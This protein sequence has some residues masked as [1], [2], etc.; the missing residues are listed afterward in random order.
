MKTKETVTTDEKKYLIN[1]VN[2]DVTRKNKDG[3][4]V[5]RIKESTS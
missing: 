4:L 5:K 2:K 3:G 1:K